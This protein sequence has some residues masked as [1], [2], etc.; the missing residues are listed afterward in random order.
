MA[1][2]GCRAG[3]R[4]TP[5][6]VIGQAPFPIDSIPITSDARLDQN[7]RLL[8]SFVG[9]GTSRAIHLLSNDT[10][11]IA[12]LYRRYAP[13]VTQGESVWSRLSRVGTIALLAGDGQTGPVIQE[14][15]AG[16]AGG[17]TGVRPLSILLRGNRCGASGSLAEIIV[18]E[19]RGSG[20][21]VFHGP[22]LGSF[23]TQ[24]RSEL[25][26]GEVIE[27]LVAPPPGPALV[28]SLVAR[29]G[30]AVDS[31]IQQ[32]LPGDLLPLS[33]PSR[34]PLEVNTLADIDA[35]DVV[36]LWG[37]DDQVRYAVALR[38]RRVTARSDTVLA[39][40]VWVWDSA[41]RSAHVVLRPTVL[42]LERGHPTAFGGEWPVLYWRRLEAIS[43]FGSGR[44]YLWL[45][46][47]HPT[48]RTVV[49]GV[50]SPLTNTVVAA[51]RVTGPCDR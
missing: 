36:A 24:P 22:V 1:L 4:Q 40:G 31:A 27:R 26:E 28:D 23:Q 30:R 15:L 7:D 44:D 13:P 32:R 8:G 14:P 38:V 43:G 39:S 20:W 17:H 12:T 47:V 11:L 41:G 9:E 19:P 5:P 16:F 48:E 29:S 51:A 2:G 18:G 6:T 35:A 10:A 34:D 42:G 33:A 25:A 3:D 21:S 50:V 45:E 46:Q 49:W 37:A